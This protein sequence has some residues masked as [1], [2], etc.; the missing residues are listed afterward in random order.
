MIFNILR[1]KKEIRLLKGTNAL[2]TLNPLRKEQIKQR[3]LSEILPV[4]TAASFGILKT[5]LKPEK[6]RRS[7]LR[8]LTSTFVGLVLIAGTAAASQK[9]LPGDALYP[10]KIATEQVR[11]R[12]ALSAE[13]LARVAESQAKERLYELSRLVAIGTD[14]K[15]SGGEETNTDISLEDANAEA[16]LKS[17]QRSRIKTTLKS[18]ATL[19]ELK[20]NEAVA[21]ANLKRS[22]QTLTEIKAKLEAEGKIKSAFTIQQN[23]IKLQEQANQ[24]GLEVQ[25]VPK[26]TEVKGAA[27]IKTEAKVPVPVVLPEIK[28]EVPKISVPETPKTAPRTPQY[29]Q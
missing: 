5:Y 11:L 20:N 26:A 25:F 9:S 29:P 1:Y 3:I 4:E 10:V 13:A 27:E 6:P 12:L 23:I 7:F 15:A 19:S 16:K 24:Q 14:I 18:A 28:G 17:K 8:Y 2:E 22:I 21:I